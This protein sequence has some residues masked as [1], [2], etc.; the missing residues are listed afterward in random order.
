[1]VWYSHLL[2]N[3]PQ[4]IVIHTV[5]GFDVISYQKKNPDS[6]TLLKNFYALAL[7][8]QHSS[9]KHMAGPEEQT[10]LLRVGGVVGVGW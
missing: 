8:G 9:M 6:L 1:M 3:F 10:F 2:Q 7:L 4:F 5:K